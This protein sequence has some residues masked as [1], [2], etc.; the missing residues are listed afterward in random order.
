MTLILKLVSFTPLARLYENGDGARMWIPRTV[1]PRTF[2]YP[3]VEGKAE[4]H[5]IT[6]EDWWLEK[7]PWPASGQKE[8]NYGKH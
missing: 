4:M 1:C 5:E 2:K 8:L 6:V 7:N 3:P